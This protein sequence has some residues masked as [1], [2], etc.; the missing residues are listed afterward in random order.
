MSFNLGAG[1]RPAAEMNVT[2]LIDVLLVLLIIFM[3]ITPMDPHGLF[4]DVPQQTGK[5]TQPSAPIVLQL[6]QEKSGATSLSINQQALDW[7]D[8]SNRLIE[9]Y[10]SRADRVLFVKGDSD[11]EFDY[12]AQVIDTAHGVNVR[13]IG[14]IP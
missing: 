11:V 5:D 3:I 7:N 2:P 6:K 12:V 9:I 4:T 14:L 8:L 13:R 1:G 10:K